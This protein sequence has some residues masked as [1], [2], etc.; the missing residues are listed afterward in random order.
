VSGWF[1]NDPWTD[2]VERF[3]FLL[4]ASNK[5][6][7]EMKDYEDRVLA[8]YIKDNQ[9]LIYTYSFLKPQSTRWLAK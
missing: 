1:L 4:T 8:I 9:A 6:V 2:G 5:S 7:S 3:L